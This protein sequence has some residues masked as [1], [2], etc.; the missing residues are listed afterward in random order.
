MA[1]IK[2]VLEDEDG[3]VIGTQ[4]ASLDLKSGSFHDIEGAIEAFRKETLPKLEAE[5]LQDRQHRLRDEK[6]GPG[7]PKVSG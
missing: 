7:L 1:K 4:E 2:M 5:L 6:R 3:R